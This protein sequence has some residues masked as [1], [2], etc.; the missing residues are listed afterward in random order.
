MLNLDATDITFNTS[1]VGAGVSVG[2]S[3]LAA[4]GG[5]Y[6]EPEADPPAGQ[7]DCAGGGRG[8]EPVQTAIF[9]REVARWPH[10]Q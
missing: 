3:L 8:R 6:P 10:R 7:H 4:L 2:P 5:A 1:K 9:G